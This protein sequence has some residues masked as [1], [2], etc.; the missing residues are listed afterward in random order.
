VDVLGLSFPNPVGLAAGMDK[1]AIAVPVWRVIDD[2]APAPGFTDSAAATAASPVED[3]TD[4]FPLMY[5]NVP[6]VDG[7][8][9]FSKQREG[10]FPEEQEILARVRRF[11]EE[12]V[13]ARGLRDVHPPRGA[14][15][16]LGPSAV[17]ARARREP[18]PDRVPA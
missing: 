16:R 4:F 3:V 14:L 9:V 11:A 18:R 7:Q 1:A 17:A 12:Q 8:T 10:R 13:V 5:S 2:R 6:V 15:R